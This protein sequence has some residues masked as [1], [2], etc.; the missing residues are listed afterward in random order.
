MALTFKELHWARDIPL[1]QY[2]QPETLKEALD[3]LGAF[4]G[5]ARVVAGGT[6]I[7]PGLRSR[8][9]EAEALVDI[10]R[11]AGLDQIEQQGET[12]SLGCLVTHSQAASSNLI[13]AKGG[14]L[15]TGAANV[16]SP[17]VRN[18][19][20]VAGNLVSCHP[21][22]DAAIPLLALDAVVTIV[23]KEGQ[24]E[25]PL[26]RFFLEGGGAAVDCRSEILTHIR[27][28]ALKDDQGGCYL[29]LS[30]RRALAIAVMAVGLVVAVDRKRNRVKDCAI[31]LGPVSS[32]PVRA[33]KT[34]ALLK[35]A[36]ISIESIERAAVQAF[37][38]VQ[39]ISNAIWG[40][41]AYKREMVKVFVKRG[42]KYAFAQAG[43][44]V[45]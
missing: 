17:Q 41:A 35:G 21:A 29:R 27:F 7:I 1:R 22:A 30:K 19:A 33:A 45:G 13:K 4:A 34:E 9:I 3:M 10:T 38:E 42:L 12:I 18:I 36:A 2:L 20:T 32:T 39:P 16:G 37:E 15:A 28:P 24:R 40:S 31:A 26:N 6:D 25:V 5:K 23:N 14:P 44:T 43:I 11:V 8:D